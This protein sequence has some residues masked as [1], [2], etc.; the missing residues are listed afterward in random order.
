MSVSH[1]Q[2]VFEAASKLGD[3]V[4]LATTVFSRKSPVGIISINDFAFSRQCPVKT[5]EF[6]SGGTF[7]VTFLVVTNI[8]EL[9]ASI[10]T[11]SMSDSLK[12]FVCYLAL[13]DSE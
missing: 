6:I 4:R 7:Y 9:G 10:M 2:G 8:G 12:I 11:R 1:F 13:K 3:L 5:V